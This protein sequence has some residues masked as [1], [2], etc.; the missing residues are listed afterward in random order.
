MIESIATDQCC[1]CGACVAVCPSNAIMMKSNEHGFSYP[2]I[3]QAKCINCG[4]C[5]NV[6]VIRM[7]SELK[8]KEG[9]AL[10][11]YNIDESVRYQSTSGGVFSA[12]ASSFVK[13]EGIVFGAVSINNTIVHVQANDYFGTIAMRGSKYVQSNIEDVFFKIKKLLINGNRVLFSGTPCQCAAVKSFCLIRKVPIV[14]L[15]LVDLVCHGVCSPKVYKDYIDYCSN[16]SHKNIEEHHFRDKILGWSKHT[17]ANYFS[18]GEKDY[19]SYDSQLFKSIFYSHNAIR[20]ACFQCKFASKERVSD[21]TL[22]DF[23]GL[24]KN[25]PEYYDEKGVSFL[26]INSQ[27]GEES[28]RRSENQLYIFRADIEDTE[29]PQLHSPCARPNTVDKFWNIYERGFEYTV[30]K[31]YH[32][33]KIRRLLSQIYRFF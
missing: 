1:G 14:N 30:K 3:T 18:D 7:A 26:L 10:G 4:A 25:K 28:I 31:I 8:N 33:G 19:K 16:R 11:A 5:K 15:T 29:Q 22:A 20:E 24:K 21:I 17:E 23:W 32:A 13:N 12:L 6:C 2:G 27:K 9:Y